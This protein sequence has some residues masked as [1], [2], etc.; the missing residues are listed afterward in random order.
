LS[1]SS[2][3]YC[4]PGGF[5]FRPIAG[6]LKEK[7]GYAREKADEKIERRLKEYDQQHIAPA[8]RAKRMNK[9]QSI[10]W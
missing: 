9:R 10:G 4:S 2:L 8:E 1:S 7:Y 5:E 3:S 6:V